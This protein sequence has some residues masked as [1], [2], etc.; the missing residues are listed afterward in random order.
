MTNFVRTVCRNMRPNSVTSCWGWIGSTDKDG[1]ARIYRNG[2]LKRVH[3]LMFKEFGGHFT[4][5]RRMVLHKCNNTSCVNPDHLYAGNSQLNM[6]DAKMAGTWKNVTAIRFSRRKRCPR[7]RTSFKDAS[8]R[9]DG[10]RRCKECKR[11]S[12]RAAYHARK[13]H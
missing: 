4:P 12:S 11:R 9:L 6:R 8:K 7:C 5:T 2:K 1:Y 3:R 13:G 10:G